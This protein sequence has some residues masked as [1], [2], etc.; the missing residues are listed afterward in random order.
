MRVSIAISTANRAPHLELTL[1]ALSD[2]KVPPDLPCELLIID[3]GSTDH[4][5]D[6]VRQSGLK[7]M[8][9]RYILEP[10]RGL[11]HARNRALKEAIGDILLFTDDDI[12]PPENWI[13]GMCAPILSGEAH[14]VAGGVRLAPHLMRPWM[15]PNHLGWLASTHY[16][17]PL[18]PQ[19]VVGANMAFSREVLQKVPSFDTELGAGALGVGEET[20]FAKQLREAGYHIAPALDVAVEHHPDESR[21]L[22]SSWLDSAAKRGRTQAY[23]TYHWRHEMVQLPQR[24]YAITLARLMYWRSRRMGEIRRTEG[25][26]EWEML[27]VQTLAYYKQYMVE[28]RNPRKYERRGLVKLAA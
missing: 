5:A 18:A 24:L 10:K 17:D 2:V 19:A 23:L 22:R 13:E 27:L 25:C 9:V 12:R 3:N 11:S 8:P 20:L 14:M 1:R 4:T 28:R 15:S 6:V 16:I 7:S 26:A 21:L